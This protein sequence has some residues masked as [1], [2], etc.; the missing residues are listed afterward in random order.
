ML[1][2]ILLTHVL[3]QEVFS[4]SIREGL[5]AHA[6]SGALLEFHLYMGSVFVSSP[7]S[8][9]KVAKADIAAANHVVIHIIENVLMP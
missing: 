9:A 7:K 8:T 1:K 6:L 5:A 3:G 2:K 4:G